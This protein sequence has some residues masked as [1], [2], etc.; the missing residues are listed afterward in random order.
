MTDTRTENE[1]VVTACDNQEG[2]DSSIG[3]EIVVHSTAPQ[4]YLVE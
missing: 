4:Y 2:N 3:G 1:Q